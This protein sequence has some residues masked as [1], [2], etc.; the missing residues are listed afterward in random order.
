MKSTITITALGLFL[1]AIAGAD[2]NSSAL[3][4][5]DTAAYGDTN[6][7][8]RIE[9]IER[10]AN[11]SKFR[12]T[13]KKMGSSVGSSLFIVQGFY[14]AAKARGA[15]Y[16]INLKEWEDPDGGR[17]Y[18]GGFTQTEDPDIRKEFG[19]EY[20]LT[21]DYGQSRDFLRVSDWTLM[22]ERASHLTDVERAAEEHMGRISAGDVDEATNEMERFKALCAAIRKA[23]KTDTPEDA[24]ELALELESLA[25]KYKGTS[26]YG[27]A[28]QDAN[29]VLGRIALAQGDI[30]EA[31]KRLLAS[32]DSDGSPTMNS[33]GPNMTLAKE[34]LQKGEK[35]VVLQYFDRCRRFW[36]FHSD[37]LDKWSADVKAGRI[38]AFGANLVY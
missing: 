34:L 5:L 27:N 25:P 29:Q 28:I 32:A 37:K 8:M 9:E 21:N 14:E 38:P 6:F 30:A 1:T 16:F 11:T 35:E 4:V 31:K 10:N 33:F 19:D 22:F 36:S 12:L 23:K 17:Y 7:L 15:E 3:V 2:T 13:Y 24:R 18:I 20:A 26:S